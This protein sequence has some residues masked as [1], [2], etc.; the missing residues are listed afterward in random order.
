MGIAMAVDHD[1]SLRI[2]RSRDGRVGEEQDA[3]RTRLA[4][5]QRRDRDFPAPFTGGRIAD[6]DIPG[7]ATKPGDT[8]PP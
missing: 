7:P 8:Q 5:F 2:A 3:M 1:I 4:R 6:N